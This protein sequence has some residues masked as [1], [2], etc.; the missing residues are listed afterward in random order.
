MKLLDLTPEVLHHILTK[1]DPTDVATC[2]ETCKT[3]YE[4]QDPA[5]NPLLWKS[6]FHELFDPIEGD[7]VRRA[8]LPLSKAHCAKRG[9]RKIDYAS[10]V[11]QRCRARGVVHSPHA[12]KKVRQAFLSE[13]RHYFTCGETDWESASQTTNRAEVLRV[14][15]DILDTGDGV[16]EIPGSSKNATFLTT[17]F[18]S[19]S[20]VAD[21]LYVAPAPPHVLNSEGEIV[22]HPATSMI[23]EAQRD[24]DAMS[25]K[26]HLAALSLTEIGWH[27]YGA[28][29]GFREMVYR[30]TNFSED[31]AFGPFRIENNETGKEPKLAVDWRLLDAIS[32]TMSLSVRSAWHQWAAPE[33][34]ESL[35]YGFEKAVFWKQPGPG[36]DW[37]NV[38]GKWSYLY[39]FTDYVSSIFPL[40]AQRKLIVT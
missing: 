38:A 39:A 18:R 26:L 32:R 10:L 33:A 28:G 31:N 4:Y 16:D 20:D 29:R 17:L 37:A 2:A 34:M 23:T 19:K 9:K 24:L 12:A 35:P 3:L 7:N 11:K 15:I 36:R 5:S 30:G 13:Q 25:C 1:L 21:W 8:G 27:G 22:P 40:P 6:L 14:L